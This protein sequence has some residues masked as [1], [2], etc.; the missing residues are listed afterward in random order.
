MLGKLIDQLIDTV[1]YGTAELFGKFMG[2]SPID[3]LFWAASPVG[4]ML[5]LYAVVRIANQNTSPAVKPN[6]W[7]DSAGNVLIDMG[8]YR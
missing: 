3:Q 8:D 5:V 2:L 1:F 7:E 6:D 4:V